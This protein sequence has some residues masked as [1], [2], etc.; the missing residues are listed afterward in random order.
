MS[1]QI[2]VVSLMN[3]ESDFS[4]SDVDCLYMAACVFLRD[5]SLQMK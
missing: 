4:K 2:Y 3:R 1:A 5:N